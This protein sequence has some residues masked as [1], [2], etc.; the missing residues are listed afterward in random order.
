MILSDEAV[1][2]QSIESIQVIIKGDLGGVNLTY[3]VMS[4][5]DDRIQR[6]RS[7]AIWG[8][9]ISCIT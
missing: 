1:G 8:V 5:C 9:K 6:Y 7:L 4:L 3:I 2:V